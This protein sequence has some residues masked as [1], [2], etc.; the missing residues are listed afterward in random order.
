MFSLAEGADRAREGFVFVFLLW[1]L[2]GW[3]GLLIWA[4]LLRR[5]WR[6]SVEM[7]RR[8]G[9]DGVDGR[10]GGV[11]FWRWVGWVGVGW[12]WRGF[13][14]GGM[15]G[16]G[17]L[18]RRRC[19]GWRGGGVVVGGCRG[20]K[21]RKVRGVRRIEIIEVCIDRVFFFFFFFSWLRGRN[22]IVKVQMGLG[23]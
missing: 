2:T 19:R 14:G 22:W 11:C 1:A 4:G 23:G 18:E 17:G 15:R 16:G 21:V 20:L 5:L 8:A 13:G 10:I 3:F 7:V 12:Q 6:P 9:H